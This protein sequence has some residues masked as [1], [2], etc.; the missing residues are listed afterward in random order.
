MKIISNAMRRAFLLVQMRCLEA[1][2]DGQSE[3]LEVVRDP[4]LGN[5]ILIAQVNTRREL[6][7]VRSQYLALRPARREWWRATC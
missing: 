3:C 4:I 1:T 5:R 2:I 7:H 6:R